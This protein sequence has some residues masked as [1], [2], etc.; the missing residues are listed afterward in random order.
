VIILGAVLT[1]GLDRRVLDGTTVANGE[2]RAIS[3]MSRRTITVPATAVAGGDVVAIMGV[4]SIDL[5]NATLAPGSTMTLNVF[6]LMGT[7]VITVP[8]GWV[9]DVQATPVMGRV[10]DQRDTDDWSGRPRRQANGT[11]SGQAPPRLIVRGTVIMG[12]LV[13]RS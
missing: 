8:E 12:R 11:E 6:G 5:T 1:S 10:T 9:V 2:L 4:N 13:V 3:V 7:G